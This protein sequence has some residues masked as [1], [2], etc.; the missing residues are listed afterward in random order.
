MEALGTNKLDYLKEEKQGLVK[1][2]E[3]VNESI[4]SL[5]EKLYHD[6]D[7]YLKERITSLEEKRFSAD[8]SENWQVV[9]DIRRLDLQLRNTWT[10]LN[11]SVETKI[12]NLI[13]ERDSLTQEIIDK[14][15]EIQDIL[16][17]MDVSNYDL[18]RTPFEYQDFFKTIDK[19]KWEELSDFKKSVKLAMWSN[20]EDQDI[21]WN[22]LSIVDN[23]KKLQLSDKVSNLKKFD[24]LIN[25]MEWIKM[26]RKISKIS[27]WIRSS[28]WFLVSNNIPQF[29]FKWLPPITVARWWVWWAKKLWKWIKNTALLTNEVWWTATEAVSKIIPFY[30]KDIAKTI[31]GARWRLHKL[32]WWE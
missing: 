7:D 8:W 2:L 14:E 23:L 21:S 27:R 29:L 32:L 22:S 25:E 12:T 4:K 10:V 30:G 26:W 11:T 9:A 24:I 3:A 6:P 19:L 18:N 28:V 16:W 5:N 17:E 31:W 15:K 13:A 20:Y 1:K